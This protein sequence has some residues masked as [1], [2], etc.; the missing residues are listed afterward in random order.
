MRISMH[1]D[2]IKT[3]GDL[4]YGIATQIINENTIKKNSDNKFK[5]SQLASNICL[6]INCKLDGTNFR[7]ASQNNS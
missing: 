7:I 4:K 6:K 5:L 3:L 1:L 2:Q